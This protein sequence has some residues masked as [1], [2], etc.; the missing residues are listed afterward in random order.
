[1]STKLITG[2]TMLPVAVETA[3]RYLRALEDELDLVD[4]SVRAAVESVEDYTGRCLVTRTFCQQLDR[5]PSTAQTDC[6]ANLIRSTLPA[7]R[8]IAL[9][10]TPLLAITTLKYYPEDLTAQA[11]INSANYSA[12]VSVAPG[13]LSLLDSYSLPS[14]A[15]RFD[16]VEL[17]YTCGYGTAEVDMPQMLLI[18]ILQLARHCYDNPSAVADG[19]LTEM[20]LSFKRMLRALKVGL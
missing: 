18:A 7:V 4:L 16:A 14:L 15:T 11:T 13:R 3:R 9:E 20:P 5:W 8:Y 19:R 2:P 10:R 12:N 17:T 6:N 1:M